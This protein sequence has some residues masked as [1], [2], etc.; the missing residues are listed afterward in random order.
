MPTK[1][2]PPA[3]TA[4]TAKPAKAQ[5]TVAKPATKV[6]SKATGKTPAQPAKKVAP[7]KPA[8]VKKAAK[9]ASGK[10]VAAA[11]AVVSDTRKTLR[12]RSVFVVQTTG[13]GVVVR[14]AWLSEDK[15][16]ME[17]PAVFPEVD[18]A[19]AVIDDL[20]KQVLEHFSRAAQIGARAIAS[21]RKAAAAQ[22]S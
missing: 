8:I 4:K 15:K 3:K 10:K 1:A 18:Y 17:M 16:L 14:S 7:V 6:A 22:K 5:K 21:Q 20:R 19:L 2:K 11:P 13:K 9:A 12:G